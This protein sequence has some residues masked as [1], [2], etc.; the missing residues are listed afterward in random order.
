MALNHSRLPRHVAIIM[1][2]NGRWAR[3][4]H[5]RR[6]DGHRAGTVSVREVVETAA[7]VQEALTT[8][9]VSCGGQ[10]ALKKNAAQ[11]YDE[12]AEQYYYQA[13]SLLP[14]RQ[15]PFVERLGRRMLA[16]GT[17]QLREAV[18]AHCEIGMVRAEA[19]LADG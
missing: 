3:Q 8:A 4:R 19:F 12:L 10:A 16:L 11:L 9:L 13:E 14:D 15:G 6:I 17:V 5:K 7:R 1:D 18:Q 2:G